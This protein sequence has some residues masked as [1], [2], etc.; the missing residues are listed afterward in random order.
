M[1]RRVLQ[2]TIAAVTVAVV[3]LGFPLAFLGA[4]LVRENEMR[5]LET[6]LQATARA[7]DFRADTGVMLTDRM[8]EPQATAEGEIPAQIVVRTNDGQV[9]EA[10]E[11]IEGRSLSLTTT[12][13]STAV[14]V[15][16]V[17]FWDV[18]WVSVRVIALVVVAAVVAF[19]AGIA[20]AIWQANRLAA[21]LVYLAASA[22]QLGSGQVRPRLEPSGVEEI[23]LVAAELARSADRMA[24]RLAAERQFAS[25]ASHQLRT[26]LTALSMRLEEIM[27]AAGDDQVREE[28]RISLEQVERLVR[29]VDDLLAS[30]RRAQGGTTEAVRLVDVVHQQEE[31]WS[32]T[33]AAAGRRLRVEVDPQTQVLATPGALA[34]VLATLIENSLKH[35]AGTT[36]VRSRAGGPSGAVVVEVADEGAGVPDELAGRIFERNVTSG[37]GTGLG[38]ALA[39]D[40]AN[41]D[42]GRLELAQRRPAVFALFL[43]GVPASLRPD[44]VLPLGAVFSARPDR[45]R[46]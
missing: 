31:E 34:Q 20:M 11:P 12:S 30:S 23:D 46:R 19:A 2:A 3:L 27:L 40:L 36:T 18:F 37:A 42:G 14:V 35:G 32:A 17:S 9:Y 21:P 41:A 24:A 28:A 29:V 26:P 4:Q 10:G 38:L 39:R 44:V 25:D 5:Q 43:S 22:E 15:L 7:V 8:L 13:Q 1:R 33:F 16:T 6:R 45:R